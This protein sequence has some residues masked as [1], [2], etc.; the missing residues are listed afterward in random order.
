M[1]AGGRPPPPMDPFSRFKVERDVDDAPMRW[2]DVDRSRERVRGRDYDAPSTSLSSRWNDQSALR[3][4]PSPLPSSYPPNGFSTPSD[5]TRDV[6]PP[7]SDPRPGPSRFGPPITPATAHNPPVHTHAVQN[8]P[9]QAQP[10]QPQPVQPQPGQPQPGQ[11]HAVQTPAI[12]TPSTPQHPARNQPVQNQPELETQGTDK[13]RVEKIVELFR[14]LAQCVLICNPCTRIPSDIFPIRTTDQANRE[15][16]L[17]NAEYQ[18][19]KAFTHMSTELTSD[20]LSSVAP[21]MA[22]VIANHKKLKAQTD[23]S[24]EKIGHIWQDIFGAVVE[25]MVEELQDVVETAL[26]KLRRDGNTA[27]AGMVVDAMA[28][29]HVKQRELDR[30]REM[31]RER[32]REALAR[33]REREM[34]MSVVKRK[35]SIPDLRGPGALPYGMESTHDYDTHKRRRMDS[36][37]MVMNDPLR[38]EGSTLPAS[39]AQPS[40]SDPVAM[41]RYMQEM[42][43]KM[44]ADKAR[45]C[46]VL[47]Y[48]PAF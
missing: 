37:S 44:Q 17:T 3:R 19:V 45:V 21:V 6:R 22:D 41:M 30:E 40:A 4:L 2:D 12:Q 39:P 16:S 43:G 26:G 13:R 7:G 23:V 46:G 28:K 33:E 29:E 42:L 32:E 34:E 38:T 14:H 18:K 36:P 48:W 11:P 15:T 5:R 20:T 25:G 35:P 47:I 8:Q 24:F 27:V 10:V 31:E 1:E 9:V